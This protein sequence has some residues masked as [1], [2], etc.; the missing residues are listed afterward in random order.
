M[1]RSFAPLVILSVAA[2]LG[3]CAWPSDAERFPAPEDRLEI[4][5]SIPSA[6][7]TAVPRTAGIDLCLSD[8]ADPGSLGDLDANLSSGSVIFDIDLDLQLFPWRAPGS[9]DPPG[10]SPWCAGSVL[11]IRP[12]ATLRGGS[13]YRVRLR[14]TLH[15]WGGEA[16]DVTTPGWTEN[17]DGD[18]VFN[19]EF[20]TAPGD[21]PA[22]PPP[23]AIAPTLRDLFA[24]GGPFDPGR[25]L[26]SCHREPYG[27]ARER[28]VLTTPEIAFAELVETPTIASTGYRRVAPSRPSESFLIQKL[29]RDDA[30]E[31]IHGVRGSAMPLPGAIPYADLVA[32]ARWIEGGAAF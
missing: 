13:L 4:V 16:L 7:A 24:E 30:G 5:A 25:G 22:M 19:L 15:G 23:E 11:S 32:I 8:L 29:L 6:G 18:P 3:G 27:L 14:P 17:D 2:A 10:D 20:T 1:P 9:S 21:E 12:R 26:C 31:A 28:L